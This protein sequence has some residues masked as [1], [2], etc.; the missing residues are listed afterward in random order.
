MTVNFITPCT[1]L[2]KTICVIITMLLTCNKECDI[3]L[4]IQTLVI[5]HNIYTNLN[6]CSLLYLMLLF[7]EPQI[8]VETHTQLTLENLLSGCNKVVTFT[9]ITS[10]NPHSTAVRGI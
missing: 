4:C 7:W 9:F 1:K 5:E 8:I 3:L 10:F 6:L 2:K